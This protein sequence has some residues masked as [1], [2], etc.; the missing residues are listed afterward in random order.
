MYTFWLTGF[1]PRALDV[2]FPPPVLGR[3]PR[4]LSLLLLTSPAASGVGHI[5]CQM[6]GCGFLSIYSA[7]TMLCFLGLWVYIFVSA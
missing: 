4:P 6:S 3:K 5:C 7:W 2:L 1:S